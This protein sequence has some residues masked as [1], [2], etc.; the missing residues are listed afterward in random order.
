MGSHNK[1]KAPT[2]GYIDLGHACFQESNMG[3]VSLEELW[4]DTAKEKEQIAHYQVSRRRNCS[5][6]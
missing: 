1:M 4:K 3:Y 5:G 6:N 2:V